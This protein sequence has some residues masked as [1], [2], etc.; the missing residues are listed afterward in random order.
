M[1]RTSSSSLTS[2]VWSRWALQVSFFYAVAQFL[3]VTYKHLTYNSTQRLVV[4]CIL[5]LL[6]YLARQSVM[7]ACTRGNNTESVPWIGAGL[8][9]LVLATTVPS[10]FYAMQP[11][12]LK[13]ERILAIII[14]VGTLIDITMG[15]YSS[16][17]VS[18]ANGV[19]ATSLWIILPPAAVGSTMIMLT[20]FWLD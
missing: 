9:L 17:K 7:Y 12:A 10:Y 1:Y 16:L 14:F 18:I 15:I 13:V 6:F 5:L 11:M 20:I 3:A 4:D 8:S 2:G 19:I